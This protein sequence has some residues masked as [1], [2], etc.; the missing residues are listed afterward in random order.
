M[1]AHPAAWFSSF[2]SS[3]VDSWFGIDGGGVVNAGLG[4]V[5]GVLC[6][7]SCGEASM[8]WWSC[9][10]WEVGCGRPSVSVQREVRWFVAMASFVK[11]VSCF[12][13]MVDPICGLGKL[14]FFPLWN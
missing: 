8:G 10:A 2:T 14:M 3:K 6:C 12:D 5:G 1:L 13:G 9:V 4:R 7:D 11:K